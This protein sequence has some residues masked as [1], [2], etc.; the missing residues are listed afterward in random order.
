M[1]D[2]VHGNIVSGS[3]H[4]NVK[5]TVIKFEPTS[6]LAYNANN[7]V[8]IFKNA[9]DRA[10]MTIDLNID[11]G[12]NFCSYNISTEAKSTQETS[13]INQSN[14]YTRFINNY[15]PNNTLSYWTRYSI[16]NSSLRIRTGIG[17][18]PQFKVDQY[19]NYQLTSIPQVQSFLYPNFNN[20]NIFP[21][22][23]Y[24]GFSSNI[25]QMYK[26]SLQGLNIYPNFY[27]NR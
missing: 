16:N 5:S 7:E 14:H 25:Y 10:G 3:F 27:Q 19:S 21:P 9:K 2:L 4:W 22:S 18:F 23:S 1:L 15:W 8:R 13:S 24:T 17:L 12:A 6:S 11:E 20:W 26:T